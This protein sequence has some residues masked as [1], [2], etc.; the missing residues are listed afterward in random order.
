MGKHPRI[1]IIGAGIGG[2]VSAMLLAGRADVRVLEKSDRVGGKARAQAVGSSTID[3]GPTVFTMKWVFDEIFEA[4]GCRF[5]EELPLTP[6]DCLARHFW[7]DGSQLDLYPDIDRSAEAIK[8]F[9]SPKEATN[10]RQFCRRSEEIF[11]RLVDPFLKAPSANMARLITSGNPISN[12][13]MRPF[14]TLWQVLSEQFDDPRLRQLYGR[15]ATYCGASPYAAS[16]TLM[17]VAH[18]ERVGVWLPKGGMAGL[19]ACL[20]E[21]AKGLGAEIRTGVSVSQIRSDGRSISGVVTAEDEFIPADIVISNAD[22]N[23]M[24]T[25][26]MGKQTIKAVPRDAGAVRSQ[27]AMTWTLEANAKGVDLDAHNVFFSDDYRAEFDAVFEKGTVPSK[28]TTYLFAPDQTTSGPK[29][30][31]FLINAPANG[32]RHEYSKE[33]ANTCLMQMMDQLKACGL[34]L[35]IKPETM[36]VTT[37]TQFAE[38]FPAT[39]GALFGPA[40]H[41]WQAPFKRPSIKTKRQGL[42]LAGGS[43]HPGPGV[44]MAALSGKAAAEAVISDYNLTAPS[45]K[46]VTHGGM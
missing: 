3:C 2:L 36:T 4:I 20:A 5:E 11:E 14:S 38:R 45:R 12:L 19:A 31:F 17:L 1:V 30:M 34:E 35:E 32:D 44:P 25:G 42:Y 21:T 28:P 10:Y 27:S 26:M 24:R 7:T 43:V 22:A 8:A 23:A 18:V 15:Y 39:G 6:L 9:S 37:P 40:S 29:S 41:G 16:A 33:E 46:L 13:R